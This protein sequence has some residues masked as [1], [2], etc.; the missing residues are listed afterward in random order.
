[1]IHTVTVAILF[2]S[3]AMITMPTR[4]QTLGNAETPAMMMNYSQLQTK[5]WGN[6]HRYRLS[7][8]E[9]CFFRLR[10]NRVK[11]WGGRRPRVLAVAC[12]SPCVSRDSIG[13]LKTVSRH[14]TCWTRLSGDGDAS[15]MAFSNRS[16]A[17]TVALG[18]ESTIWLR[19]RPFICRYPKTVNVKE[20]IWNVSTWENS[21]VTLILNP[22]TS[23]CFS[24]A[25]V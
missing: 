5:Q 18:R 4:G 23:L 2:C 22:L 19:S 15:R 11:V 6:L 12:R 16:G 24:F 3:S 17:V 10:E 7:F 9:T 21:D 1:M 25:S 8:C 14:Q 20:A 13:T